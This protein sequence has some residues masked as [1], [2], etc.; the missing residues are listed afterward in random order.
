[1]KNVFFYQTDIGEIG[2]AESENVITNLYFDR[3]S[4]HESISELE[5]ELLKEAGSQLKDYLAGKLRNFDLPL[6]PVGTKFMKSVWTVLQDIPYGETRSYGQIAQ[7]IGKPSAYRAVGLSNSRNPI[8]IFIPCHRVIGAKGELTGYLGGLE[9][10]KHL[11]ELEK[12]MV[13]L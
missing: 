4:I 6:A 7:I 10:K 12:S 3:G 9:I 1:M 8:S 5:T 13:K 11:L 2:I